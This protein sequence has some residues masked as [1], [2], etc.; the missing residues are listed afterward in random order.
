MYNFYGFNINEFIPR[1]KMEYYKAGSL[2][3]IFR[4]RGFASESTNHATIMEILAPMCVY[5]FF[6]V[7]NGKNKILKKIHK[8]IFI[9]FKCSSNL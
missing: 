6:N 3:I 8:L 2:G 9:Y 4:A 7:Y 5:Y 1:P